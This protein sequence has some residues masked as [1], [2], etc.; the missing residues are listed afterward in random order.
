MV[1]EMCRAASL[2]VGER[3]EA[4]IALATKLLIT[5]RDYTQT[6]VQM[7]Q[8]RVEKTGHSTPLGA[9]PSSLIL[10]R[11]SQ[12]HQGVVCHRIEVTEILGEIVGLSRTGETHHR[13]HPHRDRDEGQISRATRQHVECQSTWYGAVREPGHA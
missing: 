3:K 8:I 4:W 11:E 5:H 9:P 1:C 13:Y 6:L 12:T 2:R 10:L 7:F